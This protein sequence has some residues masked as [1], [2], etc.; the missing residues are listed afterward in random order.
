MEGPKGEEISCLVLI[1][2]L[3]RANSREKCF[4]LYSPT[5]LYCKWDMTRN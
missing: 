4:S 2:Q 5:R 1:V 3:L